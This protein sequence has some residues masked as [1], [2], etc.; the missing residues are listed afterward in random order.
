MD[1]LKLQTTEYHP[2][3]PMRKSVF[4]VLSSTLLLGPGRLMWFLQTLSLSTS[5]IATSA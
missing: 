5:T 4:M 1:S 3:Q 2:P